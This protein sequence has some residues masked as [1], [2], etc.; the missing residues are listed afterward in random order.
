MPKGIY[1]HKK[2]SEEQNKKISESLKGRN[3]HVW[4]LESRKK[5]S[6]SQK[7]I[8][9]K[10]PIFRKHTEESKQKISKNNAKFWLRKKHLSI[11]GSN[12]P[13]WVGGY[14]ARLVENHNYR[15]RKARAIGKHT[16]KEWEEVKEKCRWTC[17][18]CR[19]SEPEIKLTEDHI[20]PIS[21]GGG[22]DIGN[23]QP[24]CGRCN[25][26]KHDRDW[27][28]VEIGLREELRKLQAK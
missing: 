11:T 26:K 17:K 27:L 10:P 28:L 18:M 16:L 22:N 9:N 2:N 7:R 5:L 4:S 1:Q 15:A 20:V 8:G 14:P 23:I 24:L 25:S 12:H 3:P 19:K 21:K 13:R 6:E